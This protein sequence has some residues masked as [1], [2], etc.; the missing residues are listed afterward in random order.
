MMIQVAR[1]KAKQELEGAS[2]STWEVCGD[3]AERPSASA[4]KSLE[5]DGDADDDDDATL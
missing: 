2:R 5:W 1:K 4:S 3:R